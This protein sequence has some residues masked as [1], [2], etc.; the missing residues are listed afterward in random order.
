MRNPVRPHWRAPKEIQSRAREL[1]RELTSPENH[2]WQRLRLGQ[3]YGAHFRKQHAIGRYIVDFFCAKA[4]L[5]VEVDG[6]SHAGLTVYDEERTRWLAKVKGYTV[7]RFT[8]REVIH[9]LDA[10]VEAIAEAM[11]EPSP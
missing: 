3:V 7:L 2:L 8:N 11:G 5:V 6:D 4:K 9:Q 10:V 1:R